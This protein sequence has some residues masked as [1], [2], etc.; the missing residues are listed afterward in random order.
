MSLTNDSFLSINW[1]APPQVRAL[2]STRIGGVSNPPYDAF[3]LGDHVGDDPVDVAQNRQLLAQ[4]AGW[5]K[6]P[7]W[8]K[9]IHG[10][11]IIQLPHRQVSAPEVDAC[12]TREP[13]EPCVIMTA[14]CL[15]VLICNK[16]GTQ[17]A[18]V[19]AGWRSL[20]AEIIEK[21]VHCF[22]DSN[23][24]TKPSDLLVWLGPAI[25]V[26]HFEVGEDV[27]DAFIASDPIYAQYFYFQRE[28][29]SETLKPKWMTD[30]YAIAKE[31]LKKLGV[32]AIYGGDYC[33][34]TDSERF[35][36]YRRDGVTGRMVSAIWLQSD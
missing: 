14:D 18:A 25:S 13:N 11:R 28:T 26:Q 4:W 3:N 36:S 9:Q 17:V 22:I 30:I 29:N 1:P 32:S 27:Y 35:Y 2:I 21:T 10:D 24:L 7:Q 5:K 34:F 6:Q 15:P 8:L 12:F 19:H 16:A 23:E 20:L 33:S 31:K